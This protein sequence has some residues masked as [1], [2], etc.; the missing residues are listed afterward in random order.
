MKVIFYHADRF[1]FNVVSPS[2]RLGKTLPE[3]VN[4]DTVD[5]E[6]CLVALFHVEADDGEYQIRRLCRDIRR[7]SEKV[8][9]DRLMV[10]AF[11]HLSHS[12][13]HPEIAMEIA[14]QVVDTCRSWEGYEVHTSPFG[15]N[16]TLLLHC[17]GHPDAVKHRGY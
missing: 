2:D 12:Y 11:G 14:Q 16:K 7:I 17:K 6:D 3:E 15:H 10:A 9:A 4:A 1:G 13:A 8:G 5:I